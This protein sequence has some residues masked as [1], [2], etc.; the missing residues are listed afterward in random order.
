MS[1]PAQYNLYGYQLFHPDRQN[2][3]LVVLVCMALSGLLYSSGAETQPASPRNDQRQHLGVASCASSVCHGSVQP[4]EDSRIQQNE[5]ITW[6]TDRHGNMHAKAFAK[7]LTPE[8]QS[9]ARKLNIGPAEQASQCLTCHTDFVA[10]ESRGEEFQLSDGVSCEACHGG[11][12]D[13]LDS[14]TRQTMSLVD[15]AGDGLFPTWQPERRAILCLSCHLGI[16]GQRMTHRIMGAGHP[17]LQFELDTFTYLQPHHVVDEDYLERKGRQDNARDWAL[18]QALAAAQS[19]DLLQDQE[20][21]WRGIFPEP[22][23]LDCHSCHKRMDQNRWQARAGTG[24]GPGEMRLNDSNLVMLRLIMS[25]IDPGLGRSIRDHTRQLHLASTRSRQDLLQ[26]AARLR[27]IIDKAVPKIAGHEFSNPDL[28]QVIGALIA[29]ARAGELTDYAA[30]EQA[31][32]AAVNLVVAFE[33]T[34]LLEKGAFEKELD[35]VFAAVADEYN[36]QAAHLV[37][38]MSQLRNSLR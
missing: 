27:S 18:G 28:Q 3:A 34:G 30:A 8:A 21:G 31:A 5:F 4:Y 9:M 22:L 37:T 12:G 26:E 10:E 13:Y 15:K 6:Q 11:G 32:M 19:M 17:R 24:L 16:T 38:A 25:A 36:Y 14:H 35:Q 2:S 33:K 7:L 29:E 23:L 1:Y 20:Y